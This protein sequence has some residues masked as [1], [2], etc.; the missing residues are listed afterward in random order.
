MTASQ[1][2]SNTDNTEAP[3]AD[4]APMFHT[5]APVL[6]Y[7]PIEPTTYRPRIGLI[8]CGGISRVHL[9]AYQNAGYEVVALCDQSIQRAEDR[10]KEYYSRADVTSDYRALLGRDDID[11]VDVTPHPDDRL[12]I[13]DAALDEGKHVLSQKPFVLD[14]AQG[15]R[16]ADKAHQKGVKLAVNQNARWSPHWGYMRQ[17]VAG[18][19]LGTLQAADFAVYWDHNWVADTPFDA[20]WHLILYDFAIHWF[21]ILTCFSG[22]A[23]PQRVHAEI[24]HATDQR[25]TPPLLAQV[26]VRYPEHQATLVF[27]ANT[28]YQSTQRTML[29]GDRG[30]CESLGPNDNEQTIHL[31]TPDRESRLTPAGS[32][33]PD[34]FHG[35]M[36]ELLCA[37]EQKREPMHSAQNNLKS[38]QLCF[39]ACESAQRDQPITPDEVSHMPTAGLPAS[40]NH[41]APEHSQR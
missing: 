28:R 8:G 27:R 14:L 39:A 25:A 40:G 20:I 15:Q 23:Q 17:L 36:A 11:V 12:A 2:K 19:W 10:R 35:A 5:T 30:T 33:F 24:A 13:I 22:D 34:G 37:I 29:V 7:R 21:D 32:W 9:K 18:G 1:S 38:L 26:T 6:P 16:L 4:E 41:R 3:A 31:T